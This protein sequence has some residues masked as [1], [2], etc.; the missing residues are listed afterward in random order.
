MAT[1]D[2]L[3]TTLA[4][5][6]EDKAVD[7]IFK[8]HAFWFEAMRDGRVKTQE[9]GERVIAPV[10]GAKNTTVKPLGKAGKLDLIDQDVVD[11]AE[12][13]WKQLGGTI[14]MYQFDELRNRG[15]SR[16]V[17]LLQTKTDAAMASMREELLTEF[18]SATQVTNGILNYASIFRDSGTLGTID[19]TTDTY[20]KAK[21]DNTAEAL[22][23]DDMNNMYNQASGGSDP[24]QTE[25]TS[26]TLWEKYSSLLQPQQR[27]TDAELGQAG[28][29]NLKHLNANV[30]WDEQ[31]AADELLFINWKYFYLVVVP[32]NAS[33]PKATPF[34]E[35][36]D[37]LGKAAK[38]WWMGNIAV[39]NRRRLAALDGRTK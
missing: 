17:N 14:I 23:I 29:I 24:P 7:N 39:S 18:F 37:A 26:Q 1:E 8:T 30:I 6:V 28:F 5:Y 16:Q 9:G 34:F 33:G 4:A 11:K 25:L 31:A 20:W 27:F 22:T 12:Y 15:E 13:N 38:I 21:Y 3:S 2:V 32:E 36:P 10:T 19:P 35:I